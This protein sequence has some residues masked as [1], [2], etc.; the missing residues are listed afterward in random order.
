M[1]FARRPINSWDRNAFISDVKYGSPS[2]TAQMNH[3]DHNMIIAN[4]R[5][6]AEGSLRVF[7]Q[8]LEQAAVA[9]AHVGKRR[10]FVAAVEQPAARREVAPGQRAMDLPFERGHHVGLCPV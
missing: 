6:A 5:A 4:V 8:G 3:V 9:D 2:Y 10:G 7:F 1:W